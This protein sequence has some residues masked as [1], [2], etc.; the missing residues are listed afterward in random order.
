MRILILHSRFLSGSASGENR[1]VE[2]EIRLLEEA[3]HSVTHWDPAPQAADLLQQLRTGVDAVWSRRATKITR[4]LIRRTAAEVV[5]C[6]N[7]FPRLSPAVLRA[8]VAEGAPVVVTL[9]SY[10][11]L[12]LPATFVRNGR[13]CEDCVGRFPWPGVIHRC[14]RNSLAGSMALA[15]SLSTHRLIGSFQRVSLYLAV[16]DFVKQKHLQAGWSPHRI[17]VK[18]NFAWPCDRREGPGQYFLYLGRLAPEKGVA[19]LLRI[20]GRVPARLVVVGDGPLA[21]ELKKRAPTNVEF[22]GSIPFSQVPGFLRGARALLLPSLS[23]EGQPRAIL[24]AYA[25]GVP[26]LASRLGGIPE[27]VEHEVS[28]LL[29]PPDHPASWAEAASRLMTDEESERLGGGAWRLWSSRY[30]PDHGLAGLESA[31][32]EAL[33]VR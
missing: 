24:E 5:H 11:M 13:I 6:H 7:L 8:T 25:A 19:T 32:R 3:G 27:V 22:V 21:E 28:G 9:H 2:D 18:P 16:S 23:Y 17:R 29:L 10:R 30:R 1:V 15:T 14:Y 12:C 33:K 20:W 26:V 4:D 31:Y